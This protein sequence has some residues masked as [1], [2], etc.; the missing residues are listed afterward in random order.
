MQLRK[1]I[2]KAIIS[3][4]NT[5][6]NNHFITSYKDFLREKN[7]LIDYQFNPVVF[8][9]LLSLTNSLWKTDNRIS[10]LDLLLKLKQYLAKKD[11]LYLTGSHTRPYTFTET[12][13]LDTRK[14]LFELFKNI[15]TESK[16]VTVKQFGEVRG[17]ANN[18]LINVGL[19]ADEEKWLCDNIQSYPF[20]LNRILRYP[21]KSTAISSWARKNFANKL[22]VTRRAEL[23][24]WL[25]DEDQ[26]FEIDNQRLLDDFET[27]NQLDKQA[28]KS[29][30]DDVYANEII[31]RELGDILPRITYNDIETGELTEGRVNLES[32][33][34]ELTRRPY[35]YPI[36]M[37]ADLFQSIPDFK[38]MSQEFYD[39]IDVF[40]MK[41]MIWAI[42][43]SRLSNSVKTE[44]FK[45]YFSG[46]TVNS[47]L[48][49]AKKT[50]NSEILKW[51]IAK[52]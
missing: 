52:D 12:L 20:I 43:Y 50:D 8:N 35:N 7:F 4:D 49:A 41:T 46:E 25:L 1:Q 42:S 16:F 30:R 15:I 10:R 29:Y 19:T 17:I 33:K 13:S 6:P 18:L 32:P 9:A 5:Y 36:D 48:Y 40:K 26:S 14:K 22:Y 37:N 51:I 23:I 31:E 39:Q 47:I 38:K 44:L 21:K 28:I 45:K 2:E 24:S 3:I 27:I 34:L 11:N